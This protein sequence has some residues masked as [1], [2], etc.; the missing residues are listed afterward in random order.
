MTISSAFRIACSGLLLLG[1]VTQTQPA[2]AQTEAQ[3]HRANELYRRG[4]ARFSSRD[5]EG[6]LRL[7]QAAQAIY[8]SPKIELGIGYALEKVGRLPE[9]AEV[10]VRFLRSPLAGVDPDRA[11]EVERKLVRLRGSLARISLSCGVRGALVALDGRPAGTTP[12]TREIYVLPGSHELTVTYAGHVIYR[13]AL[14][15]QA[16]EHSWGMVDEVSPRR[17]S[18][19]RVPSPQPAPFYKR[20]WFW[21][22]VGG[23]AATAAV[24]GAVAASVGGSDRLPRQNLG[25]IDMSQ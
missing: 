24:T 1:L 25:T 15:L 3:R 22:V 21:A 14:A 19:P 13:R 10:F 16:G 4:N 9:A 5:F 17:A 6:A 7:L 12:L 2:V 23:V 8:P 20:W 11:A 18:P